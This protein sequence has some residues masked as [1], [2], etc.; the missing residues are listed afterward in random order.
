[1]GQVNPYFNR[2]L[3]WLTF[4]YR[5]L[6]EA[7]DKQVPL[8]ERIKFLAI[9]SSNLDEFFRVRVA[10]LQNLLKFS[11]ARIH[12][13][14]DFDPKDIM[15]AVQ[16]DV[17][18]QHY[19][20]ERI[21]KETILPELQA[22]HIIL[23]HE[24]EPAKAHLKEMTHFFKSKILSYLQPIFISGSGK[25]VPFMQNDALYFA[26]SLRR[27]HNLDGKEE[28]II[29]Y[30]NIPSQPLGRFVKLSSMKGNKYFVFIED[31]I[32]QN[33]ATIFPGYEAL[34]CYSIKMT[35]NGD[36]SIEDE[37]S[38]DLVRKIKEQLKK[39]HAGEPT[40]FQYEDIMPPEML[41]FLT[42]RFQLEPEDMAPG[43]RYHNLDDLMQLPNPLSPKLEYTPLPAISKSALEES[44]SIF[45]AISRQDHILHFPYHSYDYVLRFFNEAAIDPCVR[46]IKVTFYR[47]ASNS[48][49]AN[50]LITAARNGKKVIV[51]VEVKARFDEANNLRWA[52]EM[53]S[54]GIHIMYSIPGLK[55]HAKI[56]LIQRTSSKGKLQNFAYLGTGNFNERTAGIYADHGL[57]TAHK[58]IAGELQQVFNHLVN[59]KSAM[60]FR[61]LLVAQFN[62]QDR[63]LVLLNRE[64]NAAKKEK[65]AKIIIKINNLEDRVMIDELYEASKAGVQIELIVRGICCLIPGIAGISENIRVTRIVDRFLEHARVFWF[66]N[67]GKDEIYLSSADWMKRNL[68]KRIEVAFPVYN[69]SIKVELRQMLALQL[70]DSVKGRHLDSKHNN[71]S[72]EVS[73]KNKP[74]QSQI[75]T[76]NWLKA[77]EER[78][79]E[80]VAG[81]D[82]IVT[83]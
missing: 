20:F 61:H 31:I 38:G 33:L 63:F 77:R 71:L 47:I 21:F 78:I 64:K 49:I 52:E 6:Q 19:E 80:Q 46:E 35:R 23:Y 25:N 14:L 27:K 7:E 76:Y 60:R 67:N 42:R 70:E 56:A 18:R 16:Q 41:E 8:Y 74:I 83:S 44:E 55:V 12:K 72:I 59:K 37:Y 17:I 79:Q 29:A 15:S 57:L 69:E 1:M 32:R 24:E 45:E 53:E 30:L 11:K 73:K 75:D 2:E 9:Y 51:F 5:V 13:Q 22:N 65:S 39:R 28:K 36:L 68:Y 43:G 40:R 10:S 66:Y 54:A 81:E 34:G 26:I 4:N 48:L 50:A 3:S 82:V 58:G 62:M